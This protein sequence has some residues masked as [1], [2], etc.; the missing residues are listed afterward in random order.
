MK[1]ESQ[2][3]RRTPARR[4]L[5]AVNIRQLSKNG[6]RDPDNAY[7]H[8]MPWRPH[9]EWCRMGCN[10][11]KLLKFLPPMY[12]PAL[13]PWPVDVPDMV[14][15]LDMQRQIWRW[16]PENDTGHGA[17]VIIGIWPDDGWDLLVAPR[18]ETSDGDSH[19]QSS[20]RAMIWQI[21]A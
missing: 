12:P 9:A 8:D 20:I 13:N 5:N 19:Q 15:D 16:T 1:D 2:R 18:C 10:S 21:T 17:G 14:E 6:I 4:G 11:F 3:T 7:M